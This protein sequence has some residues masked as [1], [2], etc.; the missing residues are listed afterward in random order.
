MR[1]LLFLVLS[2]ATVFAQDGAAIYKA[3]CAGCHDTPSGRIP[4]FSAIRTMAPAKILESLENGPMKTQAAGLS[5][6]ERHALVTFL[7]SPGAKPAAVAPPPAAFCNA[8]L[9][10]LSNAV[11]GPHWSLWGANIANTRFQDASEAGLTAA[12]VPKLKLEWAFGLGEGT[13]VHSQ[14]AAGDGRVFAANLTGEVYSLNPRTGCIYWTFKADTQVRSAI[15]FGISDS[16][17][18][19]P[20]IYFSDMRA[21]VYSVDASTGKLSWKVHAADHFAAMITGAPQLHG[22]VLY[23]PVSSYEEVLA[24]SPKYECC[25][26]RGSVV[27]LDAETGKCLWK[28]Y[29]IAESPQ[30]T[31]KSQTGT[32]MWGPSGAAVWS[33][34]TFDEKLSALYVATGDNYSDPPSATSDAVLALDAKTGKLLWSKQLTPNDV[35]NVSLNPAGH[36]LDFGQ[37]PILVTLANGRRALVIGQKSGMAHALDPDRQGEILWETR[38]GAGGPLGGIQWGSAADSENMYVALSDLGLT[39]VADKTAPKGYRLELNPNQGGGLFALRLT[40]GE[41]VWSAKPVSC[42]ERKHCSPAQ[43]AAVTAIPGVLFSGS[44]DGYL[45]AYSAATGAIVWAVDTARE[46]DTVNGQKARG[47]SLDVAGPVVAGGMV[48][49][50]SG[51][52]QWGGMPGNVLLAFSA[53]GK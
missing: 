9:Q 52:G 32:Q 53:D 12:D 24:G 44:V 4:P 17:S 48:Y 21:N 13:G 41:K 8:Q 2:A 51:Y 15:V 33:T 42:G 47:G 50:N 3:R 45:R 28:T 19:R 1:S 10:P 5:S 23:V 46:Y 7:A 14:P 34:P 37:P 43:S 27:A 18:K 36:D 16:A 22:G 11:E 20:A 25:T 29:T 38:I 39:G 49:V 31:K 35:Y 26:F 30:P 6:G 40:S